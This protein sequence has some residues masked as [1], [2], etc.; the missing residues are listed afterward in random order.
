LHKNHFLIPFSRFYNSLD[1]ASNYGK[2][3]GYGATFP[4]LR[5]PQAWTAG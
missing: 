4:R 5:K 3:R 1:G 2:C